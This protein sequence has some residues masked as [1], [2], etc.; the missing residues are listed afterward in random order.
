VLSVWP[1]RAAFQLKSKWSFG[2][3]HYRLRPGEYQWFVWPGYG[4]RA[5]ANYGPRIGKRT[6][7]VSRPA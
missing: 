5:A 4:R 3:R 6:F 2:R 1:A 7:V